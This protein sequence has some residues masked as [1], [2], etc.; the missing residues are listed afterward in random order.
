MTSPDLME[1]QIKRWKDSKQS[2]VISSFGDIKTIEGEIVKLKQQEDRYNKAYGAGLISIEQLKSYTTPVREQVGS[3]EVQI[4]KAK[5][6]ENQIHD[7]AMPTDDD[8]KSFAE[9]SIQA[10]P[11]LNF[12]QKRV[13]VTSTVRQIVSSQRE[14]SVNGELK[15]DM[16]WCIP[17]IS[18]HVEY[19]TI[20]RYCRATKRGQE[21]AV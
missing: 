7:A 1:R 11:A 4:A 18:N 19:K 8:L 15:L 9:E 5:Q 14:L 12:E 3:L 10:L 2:R 21:H 6:E 16:L 20:Y 13:I 17:A